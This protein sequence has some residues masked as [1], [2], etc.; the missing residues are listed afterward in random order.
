M[1]VKNF[2]PLN[3][4]GFIIAR[5]HRIMLNT[6]QQRLADNDFDI[7]AEQAITIMKLY[8]KEGIA[9]QEIAD[10]LFKDK[11]SVKRLIDNMECK[12]LIVR[13]PDKDDRRNKL[14]YLTHGGKM[15]RAKMASVAICLLD[16]AQSN[17]DEEEIKI[18]K[19]VLFQIF[20]NL[21]KNNDE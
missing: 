8:Q 11:S 12:N 17:I 19:K 2:N 6:L 7:T 14:I 20:N 5:T 9:Q 4:I 1:D 10:A 13:V 16:E 15:L 21:S 18:C 3:E